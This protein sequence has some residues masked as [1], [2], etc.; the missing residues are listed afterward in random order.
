LG[1]GIDEVFT[2][3]GYYGRDKYLGS[4][5][6][7]SR[8]YLI[9]LTDQRVVTLKRT[10]ADK[11]VALWH[12]GW[13]ELLHVEVQAPANCVLHLKEYS[14]KK[15]L[16]EKQRITRVI[17]TTPGTNQAEELTAMIADEMTRRSN[18]KF[19]EDEYDDDG[20]P[21]PPYMPCVNW[22][23]V[24][25]RGQTCFWAPIPPVDKYIAFGHVIGGT[26]PPSEPVSMVLRSGGNSVVLSPPVRFELI[27]REQSDFTV[28]MPVA[29]ARFRALGAVVVKGV[30]PPKND[31]VTCVRTDFLTLAP[32]DDDAS[33]MPEVDETMRRS[34]RKHFENASMWSIDNLGRTFIATRSRDCPDGRFALDVLD[35]H[36]DDDR[37]MI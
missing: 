18:S 17:K 23:C 6:V 30:E 5:E 15:R 34:D 29:P 7:N 1:G 13:H 35:A 16:F 2:H 32:F 28:W 36:G 27:Y 20:E 9:V 24:V 12:V 10:A 22:K 14:R 11:Y 33:W 3:K 4:V 31:L 19:D 25:S 21:L 8:A 37:A 26:N